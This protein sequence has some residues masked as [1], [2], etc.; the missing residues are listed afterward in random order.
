M[1]AY[2]SFPE[3]GGTPLARPVRGERDGDKGAEAGTGFGGQAARGEP[4]PAAAVHTELQVFVTGVTEVQDSLGGSVTYQYCLEAHS[5][6]PTFRAR[7]S[8]VT[9]RGADFALLRHKLRAFCPGVWE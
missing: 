1:A 9:R 3:A 7:H 6:L 2:V 4:G 8:A 5:T